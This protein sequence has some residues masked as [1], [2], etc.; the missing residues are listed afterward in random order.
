MAFTLQIG[1]T[2]PSFKL[3][4]TDKVIRKTVEKYIPK[5]PSKTKKLH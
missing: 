3:P 1:E 2:A 4:S 5:N